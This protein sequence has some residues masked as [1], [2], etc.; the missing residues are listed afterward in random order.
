MMPKSNGFGLRQRWI[1]VGVLGLLAGSIWLIPQTKATTYNASVDTSTTY[2]TLEGFGAAGAWSQNNLTEH[3]NKMELYDLLFNQLGLDIYRL[4]NQYRYNSNFDFEDTEIVKMGGLSLGHPIKTLLCSWSPPAD[5][6]LNEVL[7]G[8]TLAKENGAFVYDKFADYWYK[9]LQAYAAKGIYPDYISIQNE[10]DYQNADWETCIFKPTED[11]DYPGYGKALDTVYNKIK[12]LD[13]MP[14]ILAPET[15]GIANS[16]VQSYLSNCNMDQVYGVAHHLYNGGDAYN[17]DNFLTAMKGLK[18]S[19]PNKPLFQTE[20]DQGTAFSTA[21]LIHNALVEEGVS[22]Y[23]YWD[24]IWDTSQRPLIGLMDPWNQSSW[25]NSK[26]YVISDFYYV[27]KQYSKFTDPGFVRVAAAAESSDIKIS[28]FQSPDQNQLTIVLINKGSSDSNVALNLNGYQVGSSEIYRT[29]PDGN[30]KFAAVGSLGSGNTVELK[31]QSITTVVVYTPSYEPGPT[32]SPIPT[33][34]PVDA[35]K[36]AFAKIEAEAFSSQQ[37]IRTELIDDQGG[38]CVSYVENEDRIVF[39]NIDFGSGAT[40][41]EALVTCASN[42]GNIEIRLDS[43]GGTLVGTCP[44]GVTGGWANWKKVSCD[45]TGVTGVHDLYLRFTSS[46]SDYLFNVDWFTFTKGTVDPSPTPSA[47]TTVSPTPTPSVTPTVTPTPS[48][49]PVI[50]PT[51]SQP[52]GN[53]S[54]TYVVSDWG[55][56]ATV[57]ITIKNNGTTAINNWQLGFAFPGNQ[58]V[59]NIW[60]GKYTQSGTAV[61]ISNEAWNATIPAGGTVNFGFNLSYSGTNA[62]PT[63][64]TLN[65]TACN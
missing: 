32:P 8:G 14:K 38:R 65:G 4:R 62:K 39:K 55:A 21:L 40:G 48:Q 23:F 33:P 17:P 1:V 34:T 24:L 6:K 43:L 47:T 57:N 60:C 36:D 28:A 52:V 45:L 35:P 51:P 10:A 30:D 44:V 29:I 11:N 61:T 46:S 31:A 49:T 5:C 37:G 54:V 20:Y 58:K 59:T 15:A 18:T 50:S 41:F 3:P 64:F 9:S 53:C 2:Q 56:G 7:N 26:G 63:A 27:L 12:T 19:Y 25:T 42:T 16:L 22:A 13:K